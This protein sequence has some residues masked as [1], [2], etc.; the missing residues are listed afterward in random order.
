MSTI[1]MAGALLAL[2]ALPWWMQWIL[3][4]RAP[5]IIAQE[6]EVLRIDSGGLEK[7]LPPNIKGSETHPKQAVFIH[8]ISQI[9]YDYASIHI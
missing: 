3:L 4:I 7:T 8:I 2:L 5:G 9:Q 1:A 6:L